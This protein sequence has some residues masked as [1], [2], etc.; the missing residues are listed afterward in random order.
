MKSTIC[1][2]TFEGKK[3]LNTVRHQTVSKGGG[4]IRP[5]DFDTLI[6]ILRAEHNKHVE[7]S[8]KRDYKQIL[9]DCIQEITNDYV[10][11]VEPTGKEG[12]AWEVYRHYHT[13]QLFTELR[14]KLK[15]CTLN[16]EA[17]IEIVDSFYD[18]A[19]NRIHLMAR[20]AY[21][22]HLL[23]IIT[24]IS[25]LFEATTSVIDVYETR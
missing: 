1:T 17:H 2:I 14:A 7:E 12:D 22:K 11:N 23:H 10:E 4:W 20:R 8:N 9:E 24:S 15:E 6:G 25:N 21:N 19:L 16:T 3:I 18:R 5:I 13:K